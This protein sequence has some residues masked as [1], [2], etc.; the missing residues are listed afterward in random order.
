MM[1][2]RVGLR[3]RLKNKLAVACLVSALVLLSFVYGVVVDR[4]RV[5]PY[6]LL[7]AA[8]GAANE[9]WGWI[10]VRL[11]RGPETYS[12]SPDSVSP[13]FVHLSSRTGDLP[14][15]G[16]SDQQTASLV[17]D[18]DQ[19]GLSDFVIGM[20]ARAPA[21]VW[22]RRLAAGWERHVIEPGVLPI[23]AGG[24]FHDI[25]GDGDLDLV[26][27]EDHPGN[28][29]YWWENPACRPSWQPLAAPR[30]QGIRGQQASRPDLRRF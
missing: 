2:G 21:L 24:A 23:E 16:E 17:L 5:F 3:Q 20:R 22:Y 11:P 4:Y 26:M 6:P 30:D 27:G 12:V 28:H 25:D 9:L 29:V 7:R 18:V 19:D 10:E 1:P 15:P 13:D 8:Y 14:V